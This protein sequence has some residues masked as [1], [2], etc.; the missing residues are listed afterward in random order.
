MDINTGLTMHLCQ[1]VKTNRELFP[2]NQHRS[3]R[4]IIASDQSA[5]AW[6]ILNVSVF[7]DLGNL[8]LWSCLSI[9][10]VH[11]IENDSAKLLKLSH[12]VAELLF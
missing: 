6:S 5:V 4:D 10:M 7:L 1:V 2:T 8:F 11:N 3:Q 9:I 12:Y